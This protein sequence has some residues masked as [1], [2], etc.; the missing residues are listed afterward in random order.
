VEADAAALALDLGRL[1]YSARLYRRQRGAGRRPEILVRAGSVALHRRLAD[2]GSPV[3]KK[4][5]PEQA[6][7]W[8][9]DAPA[10]ARAHFL[11]AFASAEVSPPRL[12][13]CWSAHHAISTRSFE[14][15]GSSSGWWTRSAAGAS[16]RR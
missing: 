11:S 3:G 15:R 13:A 5:W 9:F 14:Q 10:W 8:L 16:L 12:V 4:R 2:L 7:N 6:L 1:G